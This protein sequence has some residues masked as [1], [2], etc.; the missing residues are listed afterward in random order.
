MLLEMAIGDAYGAGFEYAPDSLIRCHNDATHYVKHPRHALA[1][2]SYTDDTQMSIAITE[3]LL[4]G[5]RW[6]PLLVASHFVQTFRRDQREGYSGNFYALL[7]EI[8]SGQEFLERIRPDSDKSGA[9]MRAPPLGV[10]PS[11]G[12]VAEFCRVQAS[13]THNT[14]DGHN[15]ALASALMTHYFLYNLGPKERLGE[16]LESQVPG[17]WAYPWVGKVGSKGWMSVRAA[18]TAVTRNSS[19]KDLLIDCVSFSG[20]VDTVAA[21]A[22]AAAACSAEYSKD[23]PQTLLE[24]LENGPFGRDY[25]KRLDAQLLAIGGAP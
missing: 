1:P 6:T 18:A 16:F 3:A 9:A 21:I 19:L 14:T 5:Q 10:L 20:D 8:K 2:G 4:S 17:P 12:Q 25:L 7:C 22:L 24:T 13:I 23:L 15:A 11:I